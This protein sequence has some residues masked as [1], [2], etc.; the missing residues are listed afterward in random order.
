[1]EIVC[2]A[3][4]ESKIKVILIIDNNNIIN[5]TASIMVIIK[6]K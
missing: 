3:E 5:M 4:D 2:R 6:I 1:M